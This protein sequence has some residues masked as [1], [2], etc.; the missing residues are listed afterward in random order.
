MNSSGEGPVTENK[1]VPVYDNKDLRRMSTDGLI[2]K[3]E[4]EGLTKIVL[5]RENKGRPWGFRLAGGRDEGIVIRIAKI[6]P[7]SPADRAG[8][9]SK[10]LL[11]TINDNVVFDLTHAEACNLVQLA[12][13]K[14]TLVIERGGGLVPS[15]ST[16]KGGRSNDTTDEKQGN[17]Y[18]NALQE[19]PEQTRSTRSCDTIFTTVG[20]PKIKTDQ[21]NKPIGL[22]SAETV[23]SMADTPEIDPSLTG[24]NVNRNKHFC[25]D[26]SSV[27]NLILKE[28]D[29]KM[30]EDGENH[31]NTPYVSQSRDGSQ[32][33]NSNAAI[34]K[35]IMANTQLP[36]MEK[37]KDLA[38]T[39]RSRAM[40]DEPAYDLV[41]RRGSRRLSLLVMDD[42]KIVVDA[43]LSVAEG[44][45]GEL[46]YKSLV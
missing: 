14:L 37:S 18:I 43:R 32:P 41:Q 26:K 6:T 13:N 17:F 11:V 9:K 31:A 16:V 30:L 35:Q 45:Y 25:P 24:E 21:Y 12:A 10:D 8:L 23:A 39:S 15:M 40:S 20:P 42:D 34:M 7:Q 3:Q 44:R 29:Q 38:D 1:E 28:D 22:Y 4:V 2:V 36:G 33:P 19:E 46:G 5:N 27:L